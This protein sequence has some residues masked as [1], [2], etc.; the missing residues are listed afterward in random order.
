MPQ[1]RLINLEHITLHK[2]AWQAIEQAEAAGWDEAFIVMAGGL[3]PRISFYKTDESHGLVTDTV[4]GYMEQYIYGYADIKWNRP[5]LAPAQ[6]ELLK[7]LLDDPAPA[8]ADELV[9]VVADL[10]RKVEAL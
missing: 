1:I 10:R 4:P 6:V 2:E 8:P 7:R 3:Y 9:T 5:I